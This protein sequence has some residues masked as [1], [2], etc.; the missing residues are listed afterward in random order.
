M[1]EKS[2][3]EEKDERSG[4]KISWQRDAADKRKKSHGSQAAAR[5]KCKAAH[6]NCALIPTTTEK[7]KKIDCHRVVTGDRYSL[8]KSRYASD[9]HR[10]QIGLNHRSKGLRPE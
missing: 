8:A 6:R 10:H 9:G 4:E 5:A 7:K 2:K 1:L 3:K